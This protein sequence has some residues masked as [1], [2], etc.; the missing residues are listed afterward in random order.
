VIDALIAGRL[1]GKPAERTSK[2]GKAYAT[3]KLRV[4]LGSGEIVWVGVVAFSDSAM[5]ALLSLEDGDSAALAGALNASAYT[6]KDGHAQPSLD[7]V[8]HQ[9][10]TPYNVGRRRK[11]MQPPADPARRADSQPD[12]GLP[13]DDPLPS[14]AGGPA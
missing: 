14:F 5:A 8:V 3:A 1:H 11:A 7:L 4:S 13:F 10:V 2:A 9:L 12:S 6:D